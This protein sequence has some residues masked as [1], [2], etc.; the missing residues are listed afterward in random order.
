[1]P[2]TLQWMTSRVCPFIF[3]TATP[4]RPH[5]LFANRSLSGLKMCGGKNDAKRLGKSTGVSCSLALLSYDLFVP[6]CSLLSR[7]FLWRD[8]LLFWER[9]LPGVKP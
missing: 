5:S 8:L 1:M 9:S 4:M 2:H 7:V 6:T 3:E